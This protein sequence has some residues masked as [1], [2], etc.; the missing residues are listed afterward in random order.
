MC[1]I[2][3]VKENDPTLHQSRKRKDQ[4]ENS[5]LHLNRGAAAPPAVSH[6]W[7]EAISPP[8][9]MK[10]IQN[11]PR[12]M[13]GCGWVGLLK[14]NALLCLNHTCSTPHIFLFPSSHPPYFHWFHQS[15]QS[16]GQIGLSSVLS[17]KMARLDWT[18]NYP[19]WTRR[20]LSGQVHAGDVVG[21]SVCHHHHNHWVWQGEASWG[22]T[23][24]Q[25]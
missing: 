24:I 17:Q 13:Y 9:E 20:A 10:Y 12:Y 21:K 22:H 23:N 18:A 5:K 4:N 7:L 11:F 3:S 8:V 1:F 19:S 6:S 2:H 15:Q 25:Q 16:Q 14:L